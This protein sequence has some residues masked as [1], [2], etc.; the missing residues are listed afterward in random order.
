MKKQAIYILLLAAVAASS[1]VYS[2]EPE[3]DKSAPRKLVVEGDILIGT[4][5]T[6]NLSYMSYLDE[7]YSPLTFSASA[8]V[9]C[10]DGTVYKPFLEP[11]VGSFQFNLYTASPDKRYRLYVELQDGREYT[12][13]W[14]DVH[15]APVIDDITHEL[16]S[17]F[18]R[19]MFNLSLH[20]DDGEQYFRWYFD[21]DWEY[22]SIWNATHYYVPPTEDIPTGYMLEYGK[23]EG[24]YHCWVH[25]SST[26]LMFTTTRD[27][28]SDIVTERNFYRVPADSKMMSVMYAMNVTA[29]SLSADSYNYRKNVRTNSDNLGDLFAPIPSEMRG[30]IRNVNDSTELVLGYVNVS[31]VTSKRIFVDNN[32]TGYYNVRKYIPEEDLPIPLGPEE[33]SRYYYNKKFLPVSKGEGGTYYWAPARCVDCR[34][35]GGTKNRP[36]F[37]PNKD[38]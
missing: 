33:W 5:S 2:F 1:C 23:Y 16:D 10:E 4:V 31:Q 13:P 27:L 6:I 25:S 37:W 38:Y 8:R 18:N 35:Q 14:M 9:E 17:V 36:A 28:D 20:S 15:K 34:M 21:E 3:I 11:S 32:E 26:N 7:E 30:N 19:V 24:I 12:T 29:E 22:N